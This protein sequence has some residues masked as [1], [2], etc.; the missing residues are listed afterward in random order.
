MPS[1]PAYNLTKSYSAMPIWLNTTKLMY[2]QEKLIL[3]L[4]YARPL[5]VSCCTSG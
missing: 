3:S 5:F 4:A 2:I 1:C